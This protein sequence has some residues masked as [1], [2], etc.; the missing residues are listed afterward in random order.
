METSKGKPVRFADV[1]QRSVLTVLQESL[2]DFS[3][4]EGGGNEV[5]YKLII[6]PSEDSSLVRLLFRFGILQRDNTRIYVCS[7]FPGDNQLQKVGVTL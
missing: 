1:Q 2:Q 5:R 6:D 7:N 3:E 4:H